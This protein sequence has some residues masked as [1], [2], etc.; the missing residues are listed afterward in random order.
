M[1]QI[2]LLLCWLN[3]SS[4]HD[5]HTS[6]ANGKLNPKSGDLEITLKVFTD[7]LEL[8]IKN[9]TNIELNLLSTTP[10]SE[11]DLLIENYILRRFQIKKPGENLQLNYI[12]NEIEV[13]ITFIYLNINKMTVENELSIRNTVFFD[14]F[15]DQSNIVNIKIQDKM[16]SVFL[17]AANPEKT[18]EL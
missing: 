9:N 4:T 2:L 12:G 14:T 5:F 17:N 10:H 18:F 1:T 11:A 8:A 3:L 7:D 15:D 6:I 16:Y 13:D